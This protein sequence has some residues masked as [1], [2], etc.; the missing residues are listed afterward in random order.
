MQA[1]KVEIGNGWLWIK[2]G[3]ALFK[4]SPVLWVVLPT[5]SALGLIAVASV[6]IV[7]DPLATLLLPVLLAGFM[8]GCQSQQQGEELELAHLFAGFRQ[9]PQ[10][11]V[12]LGGINLVSQM[13]IMGVMKVTGGGALVDLMM[14]GVPADDPGAAAQALSDAGLA[15]A[16]GMSLYAV[17]T[18]AMQFAP[19]LVLFNNESPVDALKTSLQACLRNI[20]PLSV[21]GAIMLLFAV[22]ASMPM[23]LGWLVLLPLMLTSTYAA[24]YD[25]FPEQKEAAGSVL[26]GEVITHDDQLNSR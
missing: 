1:R 16:I 17:L 20:L 24:Y 5:I 2:Q 8:L 21:Y 14:N 19:A 6:P 9:R 4:K 10:Q 3:I 25:L 13:L 15:I 11:L 23:M 18:M 12:T 26:E 7:G 22:V